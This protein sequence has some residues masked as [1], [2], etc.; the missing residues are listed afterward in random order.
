MKLTLR[1]LDQLPPANGTR[2]VHLSDFHLGKAREPDEF[3]VADAILETVDGLSA[4]VVVVSGDLV[5]VPDDAV[6]LSW[7]EGRF[8]NLEAPVVVVPGNHDVANPDRPEA[9]M[10]HYGLFPRYETHA[11]VGFALFD[12]FC[13]LPFGEREEWELEL[14]RDLGHLALGEISTDQFESLVDSLEAPWVAV[15]HHHVHEDPEDPRNERSMK[16]LL[17]SRAFLAWCESFG[18]SAILHGHKHDYA[19]VYAEG[20]VPVFRGGATTKLPAVF[21][22]LDISDGVEWHE[23]EVT[24]G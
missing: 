18:C 14:F 3:A 7:I 8:D 1:G 21:R 17:N 2:V 10:R 20:S 9:F 5:H 4:D 24:S 6:A 22:V 12:S 15:L 16:P 19:P 23:I 11:G 13:G